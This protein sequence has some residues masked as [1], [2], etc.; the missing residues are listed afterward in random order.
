MI[1]SDEDNY[2]WDEDMDDLDALITER[3]EELQNK[4]GV[5]RPI[6][7]YSHEEE[8]R[9]KLRSIDRLERREQKWNGLEG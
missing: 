2:D 8:C 4:H 3:L 5:Q 9:D 7:F 6:F 1:L